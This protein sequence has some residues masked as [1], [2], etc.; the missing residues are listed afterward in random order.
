M[1]THYFIAIKIPAHVESAILEARAKTNLHETHKTLPVAEDLHITLHY[2]GHMEQHV[3]DQMI[4][5]LQAIDSVPFE[6]CTKALAH[7]G[8]DS[9]PRVV[10]V[11]LEESHSLS[12]LQRQVVQVV[13]DFQEVVHSKEFT[14][15]ITIAKKWAS[16]AVLLTDEFSLTTQA[17]HAESFTIYKINPNST[18]RYEE[19]R[20]I[21]LRRVK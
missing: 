8:S 10:Y 16:N 19:V 3:L 5:S 17:F 20:S 21:Q 12:S 4:Q 14:A 15:H 2:L 1:S 9:T 11:A 6:L 7:F 18:P 13:S